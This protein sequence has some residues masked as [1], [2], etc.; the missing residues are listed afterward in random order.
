MKGRRKPCRMIDWNEEQVHLAYLE[1]T[2]KLAA[3]GPGRAEAYEDAL[4][5]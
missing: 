5:N 2:R 4:A 3:V 1:A